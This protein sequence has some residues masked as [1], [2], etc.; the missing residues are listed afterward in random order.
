MRRP[1]TRGT[2]R[3]YNVSQSS[4]FEGKR[5]LLEFRLRN[6]KE[7]G[8][9]KVIALSPPV[10]Y[11]DLHS[12]PA[13]SLWTLLLFLELFLHQR[14]FL[15]LLLL[16]TRL[17]LEL[18]PHPWLFLKLS[19]NLLLSLVLLLKLALL[20][21]AL[22]SGGDPGGHHLRGKGARHN[23]RSLDRGSRHRRD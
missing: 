16:H 6:G 22:H 3:P 15:E 5:V 18:L 10:I 11:P 1:R 17:F 13:Q 9:H 12:L 2:P 19:L 8:R 21:L 4:S 14:L 23:G 20:Q 7:N